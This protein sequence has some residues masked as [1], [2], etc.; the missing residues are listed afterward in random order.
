MPRSPRTVLVHGDF[1]AGNVL[2][3][4]EDGIVLLLDWELA[5][6]RPDAEDPP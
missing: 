4:E 1:K 3:D 5:H 6:R 2:L